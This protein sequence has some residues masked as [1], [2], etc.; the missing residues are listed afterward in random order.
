MDNLGLSE[1]FKH[2]NYRAPLKIQV[3]RQDKALVKKFE[4]SI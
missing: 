2:I 4:R 3:S 1:R